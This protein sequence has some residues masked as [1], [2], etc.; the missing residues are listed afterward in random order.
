[1]LT[2]MH[3]YPREADKTPD[4]CRLRIAHKGQCRQ[5]TNCSSQ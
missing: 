2:I 5:R 4:R 3:I 1:M